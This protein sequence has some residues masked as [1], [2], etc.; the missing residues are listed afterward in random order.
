M[1]KKEKKTEQ[2][3]AHCRKSSDSCAGE[4]TIKVKGL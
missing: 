4:E 1:F 3:D 2:N